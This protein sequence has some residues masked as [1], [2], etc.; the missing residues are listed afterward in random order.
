MRIL[1]VGGGSGGHVTPLKAVAEHLQTTE[2]HKIAVISDRRFFS[3]TREIFQPLPDVKLHRIFAGKFRRYHSKSL[4][5]HFTHL[6]TLIRNLRD[7]FYLLIGGLQAL[8][9]FVRFRPQV[10][11]CKGG[12]VCVPVGF[13][14]RLLRVKI[15]IHDS[16]TR[17]GLTNRILAP[18][19]HVIATGMPVSFYP[20]PK[21]KMIY[22]GIPVSDEYR[23]LS[24]AQQQ[25]HKQQ[26][27]FEVQQPLLLV[28]GGGN[29][30]TFLNQQVSSI[31]EGL[32]GK[33]WGIIHIAGRDKVQPVLET[34]AKLSKKLQQQWQVEEFTQMTPRLLAA[35]LVLART[36]ASTIQECANAQKTVIGIASQHLSDQKMNAEYFSSQ[37][38]LLSLDESQLAT[39]GSQLL[40]ALS[41]LQNDPKAAKNYARALHD[42]FAK[43]DAAQVLAGILLD[44]PV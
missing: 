40:Q 9:L 37:D 14:A 31:A 2:A 16:D 4:L 34:R 36:S 19:A 1:L 39:D 3:Q 44:Y 15:V 5:W 33:G 21:E 8:I 30:A 13:V 27:G 20:Y 28:T 6:P 10:V 41:D 32:L 42:Q 18:W 38:A 43:P 23:P 17:P 12:F 35:D 29:G 11:F 22:T 25:S 24:S 7:V 26:L